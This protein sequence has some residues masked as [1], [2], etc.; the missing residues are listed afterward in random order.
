MKERPRAAGLIRPVGEGGEDRRA[1]R[2]ERH[3]GIAPTRLLLLREGDVVPLNTAVEADVGLGGGPAVGTGEGDGAG[4]QVAWIARVRGRHDLDVRPVA[5]P[6]DEVVGTHHDPG[7]PGFLAGAGRARGDQGYGEKARERVRDGAG[8]FRTGHVR[9]V[10]RG[11]SCGH[12]RPG[13]ER[14]DRATERQG[15]ADLRSASRGSAK[16]ALIGP[17]R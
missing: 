5:I 9:T 7:L 4:Q 8:H 2:G 17:C 16:P 11:G 12:P 6:A 14:Q 15:T 10:T 1:G 13:S 3:L